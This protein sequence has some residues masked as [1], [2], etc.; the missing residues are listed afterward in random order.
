MRKRRWGAGGLFSLFRIDRISFSSFE[1]ENCQRDLTPSF[2]GPL[3]GL[4]LV[5]IIMKRLSWRPIVKIVAPFG[6]GKTRPTTIKW[7]G[8]VKYQYAASSI[9][10]G[11]SNSP[12][13]AS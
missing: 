5:N 9:F 1:G 10:C 8:E 4:A 3:R 6:C 7:S 12:C 11:I 13:S 2:I